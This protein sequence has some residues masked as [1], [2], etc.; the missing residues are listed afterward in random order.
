MHYTVNSIINMNSRSG[1]IHQPT[2]SFFTAVFN[3]FILI[4]PTKYLGSRDG[5]ERKERWGTCC[6]LLV[7]PV[8]KLLRE[9]RKSFALDWFSFH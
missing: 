9:M 4:L 6:D 3:T 1:D 7:S 5:E 2:L 8:E